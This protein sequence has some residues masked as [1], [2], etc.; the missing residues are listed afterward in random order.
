ME[1]GVAVHEYSSIDN[2][3]IKIYP[4]PKNITAL[5]IGDLSEFQEKYPAVTAINMMVNYSPFEINHLILTFKC[6]H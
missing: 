4:Y 6:C 1:V 5:G 3:L 2:F